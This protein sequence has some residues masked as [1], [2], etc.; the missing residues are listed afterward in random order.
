MTIVL[1]SRQ[2]TVLLKALGDGANVAYRNADCDRAK[3]DGPCLTLFV[4]QN[5]QL[6]TKIVAQA[7]ITFDDSPVAIHYNLD[8]DDESGVLTISGLLN[9][10]REQIDRAVKA[11]APGESFGFSK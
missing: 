1:G 8:A 11:A 6:M 3:E 9:A 7:I 5:G 2:L 10:K 4:A